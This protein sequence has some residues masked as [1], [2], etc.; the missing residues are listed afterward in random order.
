[1]ERSRAL[2][3]AGKKYFYAEF[4]KMGLKYSLSEA[5]FVWV[6]VERDSVQVFKELLQRGVIIRTGDIFGA[7]THIRVTMG[8]QEQNERFIQALREVLA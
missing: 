6:D 5:N 1:V 2:N 3:S 4:D 7:P 8:T